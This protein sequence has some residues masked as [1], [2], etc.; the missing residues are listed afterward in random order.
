MNR[1]IKSET[2]SQAIKRGVHVEIIPLKA[3]RKR[4][5]KKHLTKDQLEIVG[6]GG[7]NFKNASYS[8]R[9]KSSFGSRTKAR[10]RK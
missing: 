4:W 9:H 10:G 2:T 7:R 8:L 3:R 6:N 1:A 5:V